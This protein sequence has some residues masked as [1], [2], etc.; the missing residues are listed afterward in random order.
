MALQLPLDRQNTAPVVPLLRRSPSSA[1]AWSVVRLPSSSQTTGYHRTG[2]H[3]LASKS[4]PRRP[5]I[6]ASVRWRAC[7]AAPPNESA[8]ANPADT[9]PACQPALEPQVT[10]PRLYD[11]W[12]PPRNE[13]AEQMRTAISSALD[14]GIYKMEL[15]WPCVRT[16]LC[17]LSTL[18]QSNNKTR[19]T[20]SLVGTP[21]RFSDCSIRAPRSHPLGSLLFYFDAVTGFVTHG[22]TWT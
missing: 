4:S 22:L 13:L 11:A 17:F 3:G 6:L 9:N 8:A 2:G 21:R 1:F 14:N 16:L 20:P 10:M 18:H 12:F 19:S 7:A 5:Q 15:K